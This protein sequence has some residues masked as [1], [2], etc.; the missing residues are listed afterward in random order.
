VFEGIWVMAE[1]FWD[2]WKAW[3]RC[4][5]VYKGWSSCSG[6]YWRLGRRIWR[7]WMVG[8]PIM[9]PIKGLGDV[10]EGIGWETELFWDLW[11]VWPTC[12]KGLDGRPSCSGTYGRFD[13]R[14]WRDWIG[15]RPVLGHIEGLTDVLQGIWEMAELLWN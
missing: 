15:S 1:L 5:K 12:L 4:L 3:P 14:V 11:K 9:G 7:D 6:T 13:R 8:R 2:L 10:F